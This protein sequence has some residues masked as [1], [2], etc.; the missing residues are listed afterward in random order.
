M[1]TSKTANVS[2]HI[3]YITFFV[4]NLSLSYP[5][6]SSSCHIH[7]VSRHHG[8]PHGQGSSNQTSIIFP[9]PYLPHA[10]A[11]MVTKWTA[12]IYRSY[13]HMDR[14]EFGIDQQYPSQQTR[15]TIFFSLKKKNQCST[16]CLSSLH[17]AATQKPFCPSYTILLCPLATSTQTQTV[18][19]CIIKSNGMIHG[20]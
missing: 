20:K 8:W 5:C 19:T 10:S 7:V 3:L 18:K 17:L 16:Q 13:S 14:L 4:Y 11:T 6:L 2:S 15:I 9:S 12:K 1:D